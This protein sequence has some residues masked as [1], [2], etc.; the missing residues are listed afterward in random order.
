MKTKAIYLSIVM[1]LLSLATVFGQEKTEKFKTY[2]SCDMCEKRIEEAAK[3]VEGVTAA[4]WDKETQMLEV[5]YDESKTDEEK[6]H[7]AI[8]DAGHDTDKCK[9]EDDVYNNLPA[10]CKYERK[11]GKK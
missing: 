11:P 10:C 8:A 9:A 2:G 3:S 6:V 1:V 7:K 4:D 5:S